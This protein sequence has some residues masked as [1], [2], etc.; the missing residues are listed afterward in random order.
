MTDLEHWLA[1]LN[2]ALGSDVPPEIVPAVLDLARDA[3]HNVLRP[4]APLS[5]FVAGYAAGREAPD[6]F[7]VS[8][9]M[10]ILTRA[11]DLAANGSERPGRS[12]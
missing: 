2:D 5:A 8:T 10:A 12:P 9:V 1:R 4:A 11:S 6:G 7:D 3:A